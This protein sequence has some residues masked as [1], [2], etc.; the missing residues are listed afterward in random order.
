MH[1]E[2]ILQGFVRALFIGVE[3]PGYVAAN[4]GDL[5]F[6][7]IIQCHQEM[8]FAANWSGYVLKSQRDFILW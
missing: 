4:F 5:Y 8:R 7:R 1:E 3:C 6:G 2:Q